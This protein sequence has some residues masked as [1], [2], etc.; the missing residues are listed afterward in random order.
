MIFEYHFREANGFMICGLGDQCHSQV[1]VK[2]DL[3]QDF[4]QHSIWEFM[5]HYH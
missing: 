2:W 5:V 4:T 3:A 1:V